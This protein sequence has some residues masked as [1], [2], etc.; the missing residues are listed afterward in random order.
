MKRILIIRSSAIGDIVFASPIAHCLRRAHA[1]AHIVWLL[2]PGLEALIADDPDVDAVL[3]WSKSEWIRLARSGRLI[4]L[5]RAVTDFVRTLRQQRFDTVLDLQGLLKSGVL[6]RLSGAPTRIALGGFEGSRWLMTEVV[7]KKGVHL[8]ISAE[9]RHLAEHL[10]LPAGD[11]APRLHLAP[12]AV[13]DTFARLQALDLD[14][15]AYAVLAPFTTRPQKHWREDGWRRVA[16][17]LRDELGLATVLLG[18][19]ADIAAAARI[20]APDNGLIDL[21]GKTSLRDSAAIVSRASIVIGVDTGLTHMGIGFDRPTVAIFG[22]TRPY[23]D[24]VRT[25][26]RPIWLGLACSPCRRRPTCGGAFTCLTDITP[27]HVMDE[28][29]VLLGERSCADTIPRPPFSTSEPTTLRSIRCQ[30]AI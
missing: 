24:P 3:T 16:T 11:F 8:R 2:E 6:A 5:A 23:L 7:P 26:V 1:N 27:D 18:G 17:S 19:P 13:S 10:G 15:Q 14:K 21:T 20:A 12:Q 30:L 4:A 29:G 22:S 28:V 25:N 9:Y